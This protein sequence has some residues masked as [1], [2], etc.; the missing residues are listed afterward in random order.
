MTP[1]SLGKN[2]RKDRLEE[3]QR[4]GDAGLD[5]LVHGRL[6]D[7]LLFTRDAFA[8]RTAELGP[9][10]R[11]VRATA[12]ALARALHT[13]GLAEEAAAHFARWL[14]GPPQNAGEAGLPASL[15]EQMGNL[16]N[17]MDLL[18]EARMFYEL[19]LAACELQAAA[20]DLPGAETARTGE[21]TSRQILFLLQKLV[22]LHYN[23]GDLDTARGQ[24]ERVLEIDRQLFGDNHPKLAADLASMGS[25]LKQ[26]GRLEEA[27]GCFEQAVEIDGASL[28]WDNPRQAANLTA[29]ADIHRRLGAP[30]LARPLL[31][32]LLEIDEKTFGPQHPK[33]AEDLSDM[34]DLLREAGEPSAALP[35]LERALAIDAAYE[36]DSP[37][38]AGLM[39]RLG[40]LHKAMGQ[41]QEARQWFERA[42]LAREKFAAREKPAMGETADADV[43]DLPLAP[44]LLALGQVQA[45][46]GDIPAARTS[47]A[48]MR[49][50]KRPART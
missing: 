25:V 41:L 19:A 17:G 33:V 31:D 38:A 32:R 34:A 42:V 6:N 1:F 23:L 45:A 50:S 27:R 35:L 7:A 26:M 16:F 47:L 49:R 37:R 44:D 40:A 22:G 11:D 8:I 9:D 21:Q 36:A 15:F 14:E 2:N 18:A 5:A 29:L 13:E 24:L 39:R 10:H 3:A 12:E 30:A 20:C 28:N 46:L 43:L 48:R 4:L